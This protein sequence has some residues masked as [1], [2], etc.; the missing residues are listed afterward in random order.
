MYKGIQIRDLAKRPNHVLSPW[1][2]IDSSMRSRAVNYMN[3]T[4]HHNQFFS[5]RPAVQPENIQS[6]EKIQRNY[7][8]QNERGVNF[9]DNQYKELENY[10]K[11]EKPPTVD[12]YLQN[13]PYFEY[14]T[15]TEQMLSVLTDT[16]SNKNNIVPCLVRNPLPNQN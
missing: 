4:A 9:N 8:L 7:H 3:R 2:Y 10:E 1:T 13:R 12:D 15:N 6:P 5:K 11:E 16:G 14:G